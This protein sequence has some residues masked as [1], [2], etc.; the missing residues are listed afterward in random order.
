V[1]VIYLFLKALHLLA[2]VIW[3]GT[4]LVSPWLIWWADHVPPAL[5]SKLLPNLRRHFQRLSIPSMVGTLVMGIMLASLGGWFSSSWLGLKLL[6]VVILAGLHGLFSGQLRRLS[7]DQNYR[8]PQW[9]TQI[10]WVEL[11]LLLGVIVLVVFK[12]G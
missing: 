5:R 1:Q 2:L 7:T 8:S 3:V 6:L 12:P 9:I 11:V 10:F 4:M